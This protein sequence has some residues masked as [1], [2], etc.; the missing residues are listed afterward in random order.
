METKLN[1]IN[2]IAAKMQQR[3]CQILV[4]SLYYYEFDSPIVTDV[5]FDK[6]AKELH[7]LQQNNPDLAKQVLF[8]KEF[9]NYTPDTGYDLKYKQERVIKMAMSCFDSEELMYAKLEALLAKL[10]APV[11]IKK[12]VT[13]E[14][15]TKLF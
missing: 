3:R 1:Y 6:W 4:H 5:K 10:T 13:N 2:P 8:S 11:V 9:E 7:E 15:H 12:E 14:T